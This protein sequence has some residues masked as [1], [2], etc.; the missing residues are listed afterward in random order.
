MRNALAD[1]LPK[2]Q[3]AAAAVL[4][5][6]FARVTKADAEARRDSFADALREKIE[7]LASFIDASRDNVL[8][9]IPFPREHW[10]PMASEN[11]IERVNREITGRLDLLGIVP[12]DDALNRVVEAMMPE[13][14]GEWAV[15]RRY[16]RLE[17]IIRIT[18]TSI[19]RFP[20]VAT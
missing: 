2:Q 6:I 20:F 3:P 5:T 19:V 11:S 17:S 10:P 8:A 4:K 16:N 18:H 9:Y 7:K 12:D 13:T 15:A 1:I 14:N